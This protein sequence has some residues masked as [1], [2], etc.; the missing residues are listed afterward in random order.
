MIVAAATEMLENASIL[1]KKSDIMERKDIKEEASL[2]HQGNY[3]SN[4][5]KTK[6]IV[7]PYSD[8]LF[9]SLIKPNHSI[10]SACMAILRKDAVT[11]APY[12]SV[13]LTKNAC[14]TKSMNFPKDTV[15]VQ[16][17]TIYKLVA[18]RLS[19]QLSST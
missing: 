9:P 18:A 16:S 14:L 6:P 10:S 3:G 7:A 13:C 17:A 8:L 5:T 2:Q 12:E 1:D 15:I 4:P 19:A 11:L